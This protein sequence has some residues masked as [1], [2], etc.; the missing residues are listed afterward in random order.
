MSWY[1]NIKLIKLAAAKSKIQ[2]YGIINPSVKFFIHRFEKDI[3]WNEAEKVKQ[4]GGSVDSYIQKFIKTSLL[5][6][7]NKKISNPEQPESPDNNFM[8]P[9]FIKDEEVAQEINITL[10]AQGMSPRTDFTKEQI[11]GGR[12]MLIHDINTEKATQ[13]NAWWEYMNEEE[14][15]AQNPAFQYSILYPMIDHSK[16]TKKNSSPPLNAEILAGVWDEIN[17]KGV[18]QMN[19]LKKY[20]KLAVKAEQKKAEQE[21]FQQTE[22]GGKWIRIKGGPSVSDK[23]ELKENINRLKN[24]SQGTGWCTARGMADTYLPDGDFYLYL[25]N[26]K[27]VV[28]I[29]NVGN[30]VAEIRGCDNRQKNLD[31]YWQ[32]VTSFLPTTG[33]DYQSNSYYKKLEDI[34][35]MNEEMVEGSAIY[36]KV[37]QRIKENHRYYLQLSDKNKQNFQEFRRVAA[38]GYEKELERMLSAIEKSNDD[39]FLFNFDEF[40][41][42][43]NDIPA[44]IKAELPDMQARVLQVHKNAYVGNPKLFSEFSPEMQKMFSP[45]EQ[46]DGWLMYINSDPYHYNNPKIPEEIKAG[47]N[48]E[49]M[50]NSWRNLL[51]NNIDHVDNIS[52]D[53]LAVFQPGEIENYI[54]E[55][56]AR[57]P[58]VIMNG[59]LVKLERMQKYIKQRRIDPN[60]I[61]QILAEEVLK[62]PNRTEWTNR[63]PKIYRDEVLKQTNVQTTVH[64]DNLSN[65]TKSP[66]D[67]KLLDQSTQ[68]SLLQQYG[69]E[70]TDSFVRE[71]S[72]THRGLYHS[73]WSTMPSNVKSYISHFHP[74]AFEA[75]VQYYLNEVNRNPSKQEEILGRIPTDILPFVYM[76]LSYNKTSWYKRAYYELV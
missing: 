34:Q 5:P 23:S 59:K 68:D 71:L 65:V 21:G 62:Y 32:E 54:L 60:K 15:Y 55:D 61:V 42:K 72:A 70:I 40:Q 76:K 25:E 36:H 69:Q 10:E 29:R 33:I 51:S 38:A 49:D 3:P 4:N 17:N 67:F 8:A 28:A 44:E 63:L 1:S 26:D 53:I 12:N 56:F 11:A 66:E 73:W 13:F 47:V 6:S 45:E 27:A 37:L 41:D 57:Y 22:S 64:Q 16:S 52:E 50:A 39:V 2:K 48:P 14:I 35:M 31:P 58:T 19:I 20:R 9:D 46:R 75:T 74:E 24:L 18:D 7:L 30:K 43:Y